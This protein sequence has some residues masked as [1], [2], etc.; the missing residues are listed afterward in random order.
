M[1]LAKAIFLL[2]T[3]NIL[4]I[5]FNFAVAH[6][7]IDVAIEEYDDIVSNQIDDFDDMI[8][9]T[10]LKDNWAGKY[11]SDVASAFQSAINVATMGLSIIGLVIGNFFLMPYTLLTTSFPSPV[12]QTIAFSG[13]LIVVWFNVKV[14]IAL[15]TTI[16]G[17]ST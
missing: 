15:W 2:I 8:L 16:K 12:L 1:N 4:L 3:L 17:N 5:P 14:A 6:G 11:L 7:D 10:S 9:K 13:W